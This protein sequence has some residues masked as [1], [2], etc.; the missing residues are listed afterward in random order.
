MDIIDSALD[1][2][3]AVVWGERAFASLGAP[4]VCDYEN[5]MLIVDDADLEAAT[6]RLR[7]A[8]FRDC[9]WSYGSREPEF[10]Q[11]KIKENIYRAITKEYS[12]LD[13]YATKFFLPLPDESSEKVVL[14]PSSY[15]H[16][17]ASDDMLTRDGNLLWPDGPLLLKSLVQTAVR[18]PIEGKWKSDLEMWAISYVYG[19]LMVDDDVMDSCQDEA[20]KNWFNDNIR[21]FNGGIDRVTFTK[22]VGRLGYDES[23]AGREFSEPR[24]KVEQEDNKEV[25]EG[26]KEDDGQDGQQE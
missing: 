11:G 1:P 5:Y 20:A 23:L 15:A 3:K 8:G 16:I 26:N 4:V 12:N 10:Y 17:H 22:R 14:L 25:Q 24:N 2:I 19:E 9:S 6:Q 21:R 13:K 18:E 7:S